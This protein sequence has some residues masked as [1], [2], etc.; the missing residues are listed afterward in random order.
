VS[1][2]IVVNGQTADALTMDGQTDGNGIPG[3]IMPGSGAF[4]WWRHKD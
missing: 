1:R 4:C 3:N 2:E